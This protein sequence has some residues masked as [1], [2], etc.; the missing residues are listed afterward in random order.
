MTKRPDDGLST[1]ELAILMPVL[2]FWML[3]IVQFGLWW[4]AKQVAVA[5]ATAA[6]DVARLPDGTAPGGEAEA[7]AVLAS[8]GNLNAPTI[9]VTRTATAV[10]A[11]VAGDA[12]HLVPG[13]AWRVG[14]RA[15]APVE[16]FAAAA[17]P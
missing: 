4:H 8:A 7:K 2:L 10:A 3:L 9:Y 14:A 1:V 13:F 5:A 11:T 15:S 6:I 17:A 12:P 16:R